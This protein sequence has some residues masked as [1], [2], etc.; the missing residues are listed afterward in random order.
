MAK[1]MCKVF[2]SAQWVFSLLSQFSRFQI[3][4]CPEA[5]SNLAL[6]RCCFHA[7]P[8]VG[9]LSIFPRHLH[10]S[11]FSLF[12]NI[13]DFSIVYGCLYFA[14]FSCYSHKHKLKDS[15]DLLSLPKRA[16]NH[17][18]FISA[19]RWCHKVMIKGRW[20]MIWRIQM[21]SIERII[22]SWQEGKEGGRLSE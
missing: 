6:A 2:A 10:F 1:R 7:F 16:R 14:S 5:F 22:T 20:K 13:T 4:S 19:Q 18:L 17:C 12:S 11:Y 15:K 3:Y 21:R 8:R 9:T